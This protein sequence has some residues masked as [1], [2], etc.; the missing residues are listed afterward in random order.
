MQRYLSSTGEV[1]TELR[2]E[3][4][5]GELAMKAGNFTTISNDVNIS[6]FVIAP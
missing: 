1:R 6:F 2:S 4:R 3:E 5:S